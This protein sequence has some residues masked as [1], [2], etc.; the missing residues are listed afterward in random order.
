M[1][2]EWF[3]AIALPVSVADDAPA[4]VTVF[5]AP[6]L[7]PDDDGAVLGEFDL[8]RDWAAVLADGVE[9]TLV[10]QDGDI[11]ATVDLNGMDAALWRRAF[12]EDTPVRANRVPEWR[13]RD[14][15]TFAAKD[16]A[17]IAK[18]VHLATVAAD[19][20]NPVTPSE[21][22]LLQNV[23]GIVNEAKA[24]TW[25]GRGGHG[26]RGRRSPRYDE[27]RLTAYL[28]RQLHGGADGAWT[29]PAAGTLPAT[30]A[31]D[32]GTVLWHLHLARRFYERPESQAE[33]QVLADPPDRV[34]P[35]EPPAPEFHARVGAAGDHPLFLRRLGLLLPVR[36]DPSRLR[37]S[38]W[39][40]AVVRTRGGDDACRSPRLAVGALR[41]GSFVP[42]PNPDD[43]A[44]WSEGALTLGD[45]EVF[46]VVDV[47]P[48]GSAIKAERFLT[49][50]PRLALTQLQ[51][52]PADAAS[53]ALRATGFTVTRRRQAGRGLTQL[54]RQEGYQAALETPGPPSRM[55]L[56]HTQDVTRGMRVEV[57]DSVSR[58]WHSLHSRRSTL[59][60][61]GEEVYVDEPG[62][63]FVQGTSAT[64]TRGVEGGAV[65]VH[66]AMFGWEGWSLSVP[67]PGK[68]VRGVLEDAPGG[69]THVAETAEPTPTTPTGREPHPFVVTHEYAPGTLP[70]LRYGR[71]YGFRAW[72]VDLGGNVRAHH[73]GPRSPELL[74]VAEAATALAPLSDTALTRRLR[75]AGTA[76]ASGLAAVFARGAAFDATRGVAHVETLLPPDP[77]APVVG[78]VVRGGT[79]EHAVS[80]N[81][82]LLGAADLS[83]LRT[84]VAATSLGRPAAEAVDAVEVPSLRDLG[85]RGAETRRVLAEP[86]PPAQGL[87]SRT[88]A[89]GAAFRRA[90]AAGTFGRST[91]TTDLALHRDLLAG[92]L[93]DLVGG[94]DRPGLTV[95]GARRAASLVTPARPFLR[96]D[97]VPPPVVVPLAQFTEGESLRVVVVRSGVTQDPGTLE[98][99]VQPPDEYAAAVATEAPLYAGSARRHLAPPKTSQVQ[100][101][102]HG[103]FDPGIDEGTPAAR[104]RMLAWALRESGTWYDREV[105]HP[106]DP[107]GAPSPQAGVRLLPEPVGGDHHNPH[108]PQRPLKVLPPAAPGTPPELVLHPGDAPAPGQYVVHETAS[109][110][111]PYLPD[112]LASGVSLAFTEAGSGRHVAFPW[113]AEQVTAPYGG[114]W[115]EREPFL[116]TLGGAD[117]LGASIDGRALDLRLPAGDVQTFRLASTLPEDRLPWMGV[118]RS[119]ADVLTGDPDVRGAAADGL[120]WSLTPGE[121]VRL[122][123]AVP[124]P[125]SAPRPTVVVP[126]RARGSVLT[127]LVGGVEVHG[128]STDKVTATLAWTDLVDDVTLHAPVERSSAAAGFEVA[129]R[130]QDRILPLWLADQTVPLPGF[131]GVVLRDTVHPMPDTRHHVVR[132][133]FRAS[134]RFREY[135]APALLAGHPADPLDDGQSVISQE[136]VVSLPS[137]ERPDPPTVHSVL[138]L[139]RWEETEEP[140][141]PFG[142]RR[143]RR[144]GVR[145]Y[146]ERP[147]NSSGD[148]EL[149]AVLLAVGDDEKAPY[150]L[151]D[152]SNPEAD[153]AGGFPFVSQWGSDP[154]WSAPG[155]P[156][157]PVTL[158]EL[159]DA[160]S[161][162]GWDDRVDPG[163]PV[164]PPVTLPLP[165]QGGGLANPPA[166][167]PVVVAGYRPQYSAERQQWYVDVA[168]DARATFWPFVRL[169]VARYQ[170]DSVAGAHLSTPVRLDQVQLA[171][172]R[173]A[174]VA[175][176]DA[177]HARVVVSG[178]A[179]H[180]ESASRQY[181]VSV[182]R[183]RTLVARLQRHDPALGG[184][185]AWASV[186]T[187]ELVPRGYASRL[188]DLVWVGELE[189]DTAMDVRTPVGGVT[190][191]GAPGGSTWRVRIEEWERFP[192]D[193]PPR[194]QVPEFGEAPVWQQR[195]VYADDIHL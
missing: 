91:V 79:A 149:L 140:E 23:L 74:E 47:D 56:L 88:A 176:T 26:D 157:R 71:D 60:V 101:E 20:V 7:R 13:D 141:Q 66:E 167:V 83:M 9:V 124:R 179:G 17:D 139:F 65:H 185:L 89:V 5:V 152:L 85:T 81:D 190:A 34:E 164:H 145:I 122:V 159:D 162:A 187:V 10:D 86:P 103:V 24:I 28:D 151:P 58:A 156:R 41:D 19:P 30:P 132:Y 165:L 181:A 75:A 61:D 163:R 72:G 127:S 3:T 147:W 111:L 169:A 184:D 2:A 135:F 70:R 175:R 129:V 104:R 177:T 31:G 51:E 80:A 120:L 142:R 113:G 158:T 136:L 94:L 174:S 161:S 121:E 193:P 33:H 106:S 76:D 14:W 112:P 178:L 192:G 4:H 191:S 54:T 55:P 166:T 12:G 114:E 22:P 183:N 59:R 77:D 146:L 150:P 182:S 102:L 173:T 53:P 95:P 194:E 128:P 36:S 42:Q 100:A 143:V 67:R 148:G 90:A 130:P 105:P 144:P 69:G 189:S 68:Q 154:I 116:L 137:T 131:E 195:L 123:H 73:V 1:N 180:R 115:P 138:P 43:P 98:V 64:E 117:R 153:P 39:L 25:D 40:A 16:C 109:L 15:R 171:P 84:V 93:A 170:P 92:H 155:V 48:D 125:V 188:E 35:L 134:T 186:D 21:H 49:T 126:F 63:G 57:W 50:M 133:R 52:M 99:T 78:E 27:S 96:W 107:T 160:L 97:P 45:P 18:A 38:Q 87:V 44:I 6:T 172:E 32:V 118:W 82:L 37:R 46:D 168:F 8:F 108:D 11:P 119:L 110:D 29:T 62:E